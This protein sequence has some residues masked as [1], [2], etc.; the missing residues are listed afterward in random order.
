MA[1]ELHI[2]MQVLRVPNRED[3]QHTIE[4]LGFPTVLDL[5][6]D[7]RRD[8]GF[9]PTSYKGKSTGFELYLEPAADVLSSYAHIE[10]KI[11]GRDMCVTFRWGSDLTECDAAL[12]AAAALVKLTDGVYFYPDDDILYNV[13]E[14]IDAVRK[15]LI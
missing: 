14:T 10:P 9:T 1:L 15:D 3:W 8:T 5:T 4:Q 11:D 2:F 12:S 7:L 13:D 6:L